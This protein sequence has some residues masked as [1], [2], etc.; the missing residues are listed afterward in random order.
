M[1]PRSERIKPVSRIERNRERDAARALG[2][3]RQQLQAMQQQLDQLVCYRDE[4]HQRYAR[5]LTGLQRA[6][7]EQYRRFL[8]QLDQAIEQ[9]RQ[10]L[11]Q[12]QQNMDQCRAVWLAQRSRLKAVE[13]LIERLQ[14]EEHKQAEKREQ[15]ALDERA[16]QAHRRRPGPD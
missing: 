1:K 4:Y 11:Q 7:I 9:Q 13:G 8:A 3:A 14:A 2:D 6:G 10:L 15:Q 5:A 16:L 12:C